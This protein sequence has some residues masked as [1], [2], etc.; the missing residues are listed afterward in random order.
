MNTLA[1]LILLP[2]SFIHAQPTES[3][4]F[5]PVDKIFNSISSWILTTA[6][7]FSP[8]QSALLEVNKYTTIVK[9]QISDYAYTFDSSEPRYNIVLNMTMEDFNAVQ[10]EI[11]NIQIE[12]SNLIYHIYRPRTDR[13]KRSLFGLGGFFKSVFGTAD[14]EEVQNMKKDIQN[15]YDNQ[16]E[17]TNVLNEVISVAN[18]SRGLINENIMKINEIINTITFLNETIVDISNSL[19]PL[20]RSRRF[21]LLYTETQIHHYR[22][23]TLIRQIGKDI[24]LIKEY[25]NIHSTGKLTPS[26]VDPISLKQELLKIQKLLPLKLSLPEDPTTNIW[27]YYRFLT[28]SP[29]THE[30]SLVLLIKIPLIDLDSS[31][32]LYRVHNLPIYQEAIQKSLKY[33]LEGH[34]LAIT[35]DNKYATLLTDTEF[36]TCTL[37]EGHFCSLNTGLFHVDSIQWCITAMFFKDNNKINKYC[38]VEIANVTG[39]QATYL[40]EGNWAISVLQTTH[41]EIRCEQHSHVQNLEPPVT[42]VKLQPACSAFSSELKLPPYFKQYSKGLPVAL[43]SANLHITN[44]KSIN[45]RIWKPYKLE[46]VTSNEVEQLKKLYPAPSIPIEKLRA[47]ISDFRKINNAPSWDTWKYYIGGGSGSGLIGLIIIVCIVYWCCKKTNTKETRSPPSI[48]MLAPQSPPMFSSM[49]NNIGAGHSPAPGLVTGGLQ[50]VRD[51]K[52]G[53]SKNEMQYAVAATLLDH[54]EESGADVSEHRRRLRNRQYLALP[55]H[56][57]PTSI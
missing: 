19:K 26:I 10:T 22:I 16:I 41:M 14:N 15:I 57:A 34:N 42:F 48:S 1:L 44:L 24:N 25:L 35:K 9:K 39:P 11:T 12:A 50:D 38:Q 23:R 17:Q 40:D 56:D 46:N 8:Y 52:G 21:H 47:K 53:P 29:I 2:I 4:I 13:T 31:M 20:Y 36:M 33:Q 37:A 3:V 7:D 43:K 28:V 45:F 5:Q 55:L 51:R 6:V 54:L 18:V 27:H 32:N 30:N 49:V